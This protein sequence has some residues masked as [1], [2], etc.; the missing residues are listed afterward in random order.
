MLTEELGWFSFGVE[1]GQDGIQEWR[2]RELGMGGGQRA[3]WGGKEADAEIAKEE[4][5]EQ[6]VRRE[7]LRLHV[8][9]WGPLHC[10]PA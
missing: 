5:E 3:S 6:A 10:L 8:L 7:G 2:P 9:A 4:A 1:V